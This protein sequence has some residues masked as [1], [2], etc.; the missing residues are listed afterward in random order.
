MTQPSHI[1]DSGYKCFWNTAIWPP[2]C[3]ADMSTEE[4]GMICQHLVGK[5]VGFPET[6]S[7]K[8]S[9]LIDGTLL[10]HGVDNSIHW[11]EVPTLP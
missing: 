10:K 2:K 8:G 6:R 11:Q 7:Q 4:R 3:D 9:A 5:G 1:S